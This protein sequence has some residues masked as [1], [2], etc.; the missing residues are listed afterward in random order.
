MNAVLFDMDGLMFDTESVWA[1]AWDYAG[2]KIG[3]GSLEYM[4]IETL[5]M[6]IKGVYEICKEKFGKDYDVDL[7][8]A[9]RN[10]Y[11]HDYYLSNPV[12]LKKGL[13]ELLDYLKAKNIKMAVASSSPKEEVERYLKS[14]GT[15]GYFS[16]VICGDMITHSKP[17]PEIYERAAALVGEKPKDCL[18]LEDARAGLWSAYNAGCKT[19]MIPDLWQPD[20]ETE[21]ILYAKLNDLTEVKKLI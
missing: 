8:M 1:K 10:N 14:S 2:K 3:A 18:A 5:G 11:V 20:E 15:Y 7:L 9:T 13:V 16:A 19:V 4:N 17:H 21:K 6:T 12:P